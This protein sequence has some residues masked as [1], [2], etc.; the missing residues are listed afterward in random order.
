[1]YVFSGVSG[2][3]AADIATV[4]SV[5]KAA[6][7]ARPGL[8]A[9]RNR[10]PCSPRRRRMARTI[11]PSLALC[12][13]VG[14]TTLSVRLASSSR[15]HPAARLLAVALYHRRS[16]IPQAASRVSA[17]APASAGA[18]LRSNPLRCRRG[19]LPVIVVGGHVGGS[20][21]PTRIR[22]RSPW[23]TALRGASR[24]FTHRAAL[25]AGWR[26]RDAALIAAWGLPFFFFHGGGV[27]AGA[28]PK[29]PFFPLP[30]GQKKPKFVTIA[31]GRT[32]GAAFATLH[33]PIVFF[34]PRWSLMVIIR[35]RARRVAGDPDRRRRFLLPVGDADRRRSACNTAS[36]DHGDWGSASSL[37]RSSWLLRC[38]PRSRRRCQSDDAAAF[39]YNFF[40][41]ARG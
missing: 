23:S 25:W 12:P 7:A 28:G 10:S 18:R 21:R 16:F 17:A 33:N 1:M 6:A 31:L 5:M 29:K 36:S 4:G 39:V 19:W 30:G 2:L 8:P 22:L 40:L 24:L 26:L 35:L 27:G 15:P 20:R 11:P 41:V 34:S 14:I 37:P 3:E 13:R 38:L 32:L 9:A